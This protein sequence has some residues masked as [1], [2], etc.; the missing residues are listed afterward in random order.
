[1]SAYLHR[2]PHTDAFL[3]DYKVIGFCILPTPWLRPKLTPPFAVLPTR[4]NP[5]RFEE[6]KRVLTRK[7]TRGEGRG[8]TETPRRGADEV[9]PVVGGGLC[10]DVAVG[11]G[12][13]TIPV[14]GGDTGDDG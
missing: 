7:E 13:C 2:L 11:A 5:K 3:I 1:M 8:S 12:K 6:K 10:G 9:R 4:K 14:S